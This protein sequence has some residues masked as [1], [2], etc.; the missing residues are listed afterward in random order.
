MRGTS[1]GALAIGAEREWDG[2]FFLFYCCRFFCEPSPLCV[3][4]GGGSVVGLLAQGL[5]SSRTAA[6]LLDKVV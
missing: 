3:G 4:G 5:C 6:V 1:G 2:L